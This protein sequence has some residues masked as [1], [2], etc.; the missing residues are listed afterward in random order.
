M[1]RKYLATSDAD[2]LG[3]CMSEKP[4][5]FWCT[6]A[7]GRQVHAVSSAATNR[8]AARPSTL[9]QAGGP[10]VIERADFIQDSAPGG[11][12]PAVQ[13]LAISGGAVQFWTAMGFRPVMGLTGPQFF[14][15]PAHTFTLSG[16][17]THTG[18]THTYT[19]TCPPPLYSPPSP[20]VRGFGS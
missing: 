17:P 10:V 19:H 4:S 3:F 7:S 8:R 14:L 18:P 20:P 2:E 12:Q 5:G 16:V 11:R 6:R 9:G 1:W 15:I 13:G